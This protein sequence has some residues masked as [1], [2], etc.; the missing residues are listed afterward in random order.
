MTK[1]LSLSEYEHIAKAKS[2]FDLA[3]GYP[4]FPSIQRQVYSEYGNNKF[5]AKNDLS[6]EFILTNKIKKH[7]GLSHSLRES[8]GRLV[9]NASIAIHISSLC[10]ERKKNKNIVLIPSP[11][12]ELAPKIFQIYGHTPK[13][14]HCFGDSGFNIE[15]LLLSICEET[16]AL[17][18]CSPNNPTGHSICQSDMA[19]IKNIC[20][21]KSILLILDK[22]FLGVCKT[23]FTLDQEEMNYLDNS[24]DWL[25]IWD[26]GKS[27]DFSHN[28]ISIIVS[29]NSLTKKISYFIDLFQFQ[30]PLSTIKFFNWFFCSEIIDSYNSIRRET[31][32]NNYNYIKEIKNLGYIGDR[33]ECSFV[34]IFIQNNDLFVA[35]TLSDFCSVGTVPLSIFSLN[36]NK[37]TN[38]LRLSLARE[39]WYFKSA[40]QEI[41]SGFKV[42]KIS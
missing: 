1:P 16:K 18:L 10:I 41:K 7:L 6:N 36:S 2:Q 30:I 8:T 38:G 14:I 25:L 15:N 29:S 5:I 24:F 13:L 21:E 20:K 31:I 22:V 4:L 23:I 33:S 9:L 35:S 3:T 27:F 19:V 28:K 37:N 42:N 32:N 40:I 39:E 26:T 11:T 34:S 17:Y 12:F